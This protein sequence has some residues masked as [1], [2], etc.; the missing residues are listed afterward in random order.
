MTE[1]ASRSPGGQGRRGGRVIESARPRAGALTGRAPLVLHAARVGARGTTAALQTLPDPTLRW[2]AATSV[3]L[4]AG[5][6]LAGAPRLVTA[7]GL[8]PAAFLGA[9]IVLRPPTSLVP[10][11]GI[12]NSRIP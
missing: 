2:L 6:H 1:G 4:G 5:L 11:Q 7:A 12:E 9:A 10:A 8:A 3:G